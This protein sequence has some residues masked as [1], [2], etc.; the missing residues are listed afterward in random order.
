[1]F[2]GAVQVVEIVENFRQIIHNIQIELIFTQCL[3][4]TRVLPHPAAWND[5]VV[6]VGHGYAGS[7]LEEIVVLHL[8]MPVRMNAE[9]PVKPIV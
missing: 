1:M 2:A 7:F 5:Q 8:H 4:Q 6:L 3:V 9:L